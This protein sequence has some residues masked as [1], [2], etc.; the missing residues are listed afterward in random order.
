MPSEQDRGTRVPSADLLVVCPQDER[1]LG[2]GD[3]ASRS[4]TSRTL[5]HRQ[6]QPRL[7]RRSHPADGH[8]PSPV[9]PDLSVTIEHVDQSVVV[10]VAGEVD[11]SSVEQLRD[12]IQPALAPAQTVVMDLSGLTFA[13]SSL[14]SVLATARG[15]LTRSGG[16]LL[17]RNPSEQARR[18]LTLGQLDHLVH[19]EIDR[20]NEE[21]G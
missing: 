20:Q 3:R 19:D 13:D 21:R 7:Q 17:L 9:S 11:L 4:E 10:T 18:V 14:L 12:A 15:A 16:S 8:Y 1:R 2:T 5:G 6:R